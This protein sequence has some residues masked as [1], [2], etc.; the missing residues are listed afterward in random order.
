[1]AS[2]NLAAVKQSFA[3]FISSLQK[4]FGQV[5]TELSSAPSNVQDALSTLDSVYG[6]LKTDVA[7]ATSLPQ[8]E[9]ALQSLGTNPQLKA[10]STTL[11]SYHTAQCGGST[12]DTP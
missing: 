3:A 6:K 9:S 1:L 5:G 8:L 11:E 12:P 2:G 4:A 7:N 10:A